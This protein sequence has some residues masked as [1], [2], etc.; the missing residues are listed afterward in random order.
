MSLA[1]TWV[2]RGT[3]W[4]GVNLFVSAH[5]FIELVYQ[6]LGLVNRLIR[7]LDARQTVSPSKGRSLIKAKGTEK[8]TSTSH[9]HHTYITCMTVFVQVHL[10]RL[11]KR[12]A[13]VA[14][15]A[16]LAAHTNMAAQAF[17][18]RRTL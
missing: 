4:P 18:N 13:R 15:R 5:I 12:A 8:R 1:R 3:V 14:V 2:W 10:D 11:H 7:K 6:R 9:L 17:E 16:A